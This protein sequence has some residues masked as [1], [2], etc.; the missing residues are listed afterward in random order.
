MFFSLYETVSPIEDPIVKEVS[1][2]LREWCIIWRRLY[3]VG[4]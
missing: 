1:Y 2:V 3:Q 4:Y